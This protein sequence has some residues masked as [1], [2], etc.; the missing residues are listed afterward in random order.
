MPKL[1]AWRSVSAHWLPKFS[2]SRTSG[3]A[4][5]ALVM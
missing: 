3:L 4:A 2:S 1:T 5:I